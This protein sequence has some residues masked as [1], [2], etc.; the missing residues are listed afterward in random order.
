MQLQDDS[1]MAIRRVSAD[2]LLAGE[3]A[4]KYRVQLERAEVFP[5]AANWRYIIDYGMY[6]LAPLLMRKYFMAWLCDE[7]DRSD[8]HT[9]VL[10]NMP[11]Y[12][13]AIPRDVALDSVYRD[14]V[15]APDAVMSLIDKAQLFDAPTLT[16][17]LDDCENARFVAECLSF[18]QPDY[19]EDDLYSMRLLLDA[20]RNLPELGEMRT[21][22]SIFGSDLRFVCPNGHSNNARTVFCDHCGRDIHGLEEKHY[23]MIDNFAKRIEILQRLLA[24][25]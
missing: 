11:E 2:T 16:H 4:E 22:R 8:Y 5:S 17:M 9:L 10:D 15:T 25:I 7:T 13:Q 1:D 18:M 3:R 12:M 19:T 23:I 21:Q 14:T 20:L 6:T 24:D